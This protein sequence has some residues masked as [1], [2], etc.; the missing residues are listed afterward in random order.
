MVIDAV[1][2]TGHRPVGHAISL[3]R[4]AEPRSQPAGPIGRTQHSPSDR[5][6]A[7]ENLHS[8]GRSSHRGVQQLSSEQWRVWWR[9]D[10]RHAIELASLGA[11]H[12]HRVHRLDRVQANWR[13][14]CRLGP[15]GECHSDSV[16]GVDHHA[17]VTV[18]QPQLV[19]VGGYQQG[20]AQIPFAIVGVAGLCLRQP[21]FDFTAPSCDAE[22]PSAV[23][24]Q[25]PVTVQARRER[26]ARRPSWRPLWW[27]LRTVGPVRRAALGLPAA[28]ARHPLQQIRRRLHRSGAPPPRRRDQRLEW[29]SPVDRSLPR[30]ATC[31][32][33]G[34]R[35]GWV[36]RC[37]CGMSLNAD[38]S[39]PSSTLGLP[40]ARAM[41]A[42]TAPAS[43]EESWS[44]SPTITSRASGRRASSRRAIIVRDTIDISSTTTRSWGRRLRHDDETVHG[45]PAP[46]RAAG[47]ASMLICP[48][49]GI[50]LP[51]SARR[52][53]YGP[54]RPV[55]PPP[56][57]SARRAQS[58]AAHRA[59]R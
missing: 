15:A 2:V 49:A 54:R 21:A 47:A 18:E 23:R 34:R 59:G 43:T 38:S 40:G 14:Q 41:S 9:H 52:R 20:T 1:E 17:R 46:S 35:R 28:P 31:E 26:S 12:R 50:G 5:L 39:P 13:E 16:R 37:R 48:R 25:Q 22:G 57:R 19:V 56:S 36:P 11:V 4:S 8:L 10:E 55:G 44:G 42:S 24:A 45:S 33:A 51:D 29:P 58:A 7:A 30:I 32:S 53:P 27:R 6:L 3:I